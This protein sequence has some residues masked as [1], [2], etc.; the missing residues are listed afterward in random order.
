M[1][2]RIVALTRELVACPGVPAGHQDNFCRIACAAR[3]AGPH[4]ACLIVSVY[5]AGP[6]VSTPSFHTCVT[7]FGS[8]RTSTFSTGLSATAITSAAQPS[9]NRPASGALG[10]SVMRD[11]RRRIS[12]SRFLCNK[13]VAVYL[14]V[15]QPHTFSKMYC[16]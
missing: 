7:F 12:R 13:A 15:H 2:L 4:R 10:P 9:C 3:R 8:V 5:A 16:V 11:H 6:L 14:E 1:S